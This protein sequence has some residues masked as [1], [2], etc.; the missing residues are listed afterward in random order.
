MVKRRTR[1]IFE[2]GIGVIGLLA[3]VRIWRALSDDA[4][5]EGNQVSMSGLAV[6]LLS[7]VLSIWARDRDVGGIRTSRRRSMLFSAGQLGLRRKFLPQTTAFRRYFGLG[8][9]AGVVTYRLWYGVL[10][11]LPGS[12]E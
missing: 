7:G 1:A 4:D 6:G 12:D 5:E 2:F 9:T 3:Q 10:R 8:Q 11:P